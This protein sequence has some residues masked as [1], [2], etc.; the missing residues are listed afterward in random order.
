MLLGEVPAAFHAGIHEILL[1]AFGLAWA[2][3]LGRSGSDAAPIGIG[4][5]GHGRHEELSA[6]VDLTRTVGWFTTKYPVSLKVGGKFGGPIG[7]L[8][9]A[10][11]TAGEA[12]LGPLVKDA[13]EQLRALPDPLT[14]GVLRYLNSD[15][16]LGGSDPAI[17]FNYLGRLGGASG[18]SADLWGISQDGMPLTGAATAVPMPMSHTV[19][20]NAVT[21]DT[22]TG[23]QLHAAWT[24]ATSVL[25]HAQVTR[26]SELWFRGPGRH[27]RAC[28]PRRGRVDAVGHHAG[29][30]ERSSRSTSLPANSGSPTSCR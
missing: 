1:I 19:E 23:P 9:W 17:G 8:S 21:V 15:V 10:Q 5:E 28:A 4:V 14:Y 24:W 20:L 2:E 3:F 11:V 30:A 13:K 6:E 22:D 27:L 12:G 25:E 26:L 29:P 18:S 16:D 7:A